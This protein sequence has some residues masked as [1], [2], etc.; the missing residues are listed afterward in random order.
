M[1]G[2]LA[3]P[4]TL[5]QPEL[6][7]AIVNGAKVTDAEA[8]AAGV[9]GLYIDLSGCKVCR[10]GVPATCTGT[11]I[12]PDL[13]LSARHCSD[14]PASLN[15]TLE[16]VV[17]GSD[18]LQT[19]APSRQIERIVSPADYGINVEG[20]DLLLIKMRG[21]APSPWRPVDVPLRLLP[22]QKEQKEAERLGS[23]FFP[24]GIG[25]PE[26]TTFG[27]GQQSTEGESSVEAYSAGELRRLGVQ[28]RTE[29]RPWAPGFL[30]T[31]VTRG[32]GT[33]AGDSGSAALIGLSDP[34]G[35]GQRQVLLGVQ[36][37]ASKPCVDNQAVWVFPQ[38][39]SDFLLR[40][41]ADLG[42]PLRP[43]LSWRDYNSS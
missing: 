34:S 14:V 9:V 12:A 32:T 42:S 1:F 6:A 27:Y 22:T 23:P 30:T 15:G 31:P 3:A 43:G 16:K 25:L 36:A 11:L 18:M 39:F 5:Q 33:C 28:V 35:E 29:V 24:S 41:S 2:A 40:A 21:E 13:V 38:S 4:L 10:K 20:N 37:A 8:A 26:A 17:F 19:G 7:S